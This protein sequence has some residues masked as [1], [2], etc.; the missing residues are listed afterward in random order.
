V[1]G[2]QQGVRRDHQVTLSPS[3]GG[4]EAARQQ[5]DSHRRSRVRVAIRA[6]GGIGGMLI[7]CAGGEVGR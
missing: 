6:C 5:C 3:P 4:I 1:A 2:A 7:F